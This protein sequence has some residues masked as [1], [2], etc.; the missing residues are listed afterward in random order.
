LKKQKDEWKSN[1]DKQHKDMVAE[2]DK[3]RLEFETRFKLHH[4]RLFDKSKDEIA[5]VTAE[6]EKKKKDRK[7]T[8]TKTVT[9]TT[10]EFN[11]TLSKL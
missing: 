9:I 8:Y 6:T 7:D 3:L 5:V 4:K 10:E 11:T 1:W 2:H